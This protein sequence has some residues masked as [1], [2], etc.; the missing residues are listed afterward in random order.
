MSRLL[1]FVVF[2]GDVGLQGLHMRIKEVF[3]GLFPGTWANWHGIVR[4]LLLNL[5][6]SKSCR[7]IFP[8]WCWLK[9]GWLDEGCWGPFWHLNNNSVMARVVPCSAA[10]LCLDPPAVSPK[11]L[12]ALTE[13]RILQNFSS[14]STSAMLLFLF[15]SPDL[16]TVL[17]GVD[18][19]ISTWE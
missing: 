17:W 6:T 9:W 1:T 5:L 14:I 10:L 15:A 13:V 19:V 12:K 7:G 11:N 2:F 3:L 18:L 8:Q 4:L 16:Q